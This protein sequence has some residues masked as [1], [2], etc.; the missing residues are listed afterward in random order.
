MQFLPTLLVGASALVACVSAQTFTDCDPTNVTCPN[1]PA[2]GISHNFVFNTSSTVSDSFNVTSG[3]LVY[4]TDGSE[5]TINKR[6]DSPT[7][8][9]K[10]YIFFGS[11]SVIMKAAKGQGIVSSIVLE[12]DDLDE[13]DWEFLGGNGTHVETNYFGKG[14]TTSF[15]RA[16]YHPMATDPRETFHNY[17]IHWTSDKLEWY[18]DSELIRTLPYAAANGGHNYP[19]TPMT[20]RLGI[21][22]GGDPDNKN[23]TI[24]WAGGLSDFSKGPYTMTVKSTDVS[25]FSTGAKEY[26]WTDKSGSWQSIKAI[27]GNSTVAKAIEK[28]ENPGLS[29]SEKF[30]ALPQTTK[31]AVYAGSAAAAALLFS[32]FLFTCIRRRKQGKKEREEYNAKVERDRAEEFKNQVELREKGLG[33]WDKGA[34][35][36]QGDDALGGWGGTYVPQGIKASDFPEPK[37]PANVA[38]NELPPRVNSPISRSQTPSLVSPIPQ[39]PRTWNG[40][41]SAGL[42]NSAGNA[43]TGGYGGSN[44]IA[45][46][47]SF[48]VTSPAPS[49]SRGYPGGYS[50]GGYQKF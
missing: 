13:V 7:I 23:G 20:V 18:I 3:A 29:I 11:V 19:Q 12:S 43:Y 1:D 50:N 17:T 4:G 22:A 45:R 16:I 39:S 36:R 42:T 8:Q 6:K 44:N 5:Y 40:G 24:E 14:N 32:A 10:F 25:D 47:P 49:Q 2:L 26:E 31:L 30:A 9:S 27:S 48:P 35:E 33:G 38:V 21:W 15:D 37:S 46:S 41:M 34:Y 28:T